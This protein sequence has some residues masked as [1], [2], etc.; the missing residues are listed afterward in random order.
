MLAHFRW[1]GR[2]HSLQLMELKAVNFC[3]NSFKQ[4][5]QKSTSSSD[6]ED[7][8]AVARM[9]GVSLAR[10]AG[11]AFLAAL[12][13]LSGVAFLAALARLAGVA[14]LLTFFVFHR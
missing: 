5:M 9:A 12:A 10:L 2:S 8:F 13:R 1:K 11:V 14:V 6:D 7:S 3:G 4:V